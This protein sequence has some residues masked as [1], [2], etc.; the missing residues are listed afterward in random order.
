MIVGNCLCYSREMDPNKNLDRENRNLELNIRIYAY[1][2]Y[3]EEIL[4]LKKNIISI[5]KE[6][7]E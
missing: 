6:A 3:S 4:E 2:K 1:P 5:E 7:L